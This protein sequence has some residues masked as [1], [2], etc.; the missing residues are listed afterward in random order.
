MAKIG[1]ICK[2]QSGGTPSKANQSFYGGQIPWITTVSLNGS[3]IDET[4][5]IEWIT[6][7]AIKNSAAK[8]VPENSILIGTRVGIGKTAINRVAMSTSQDVISLT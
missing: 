7:G 4:N 8:L 5:A 3:Y 6:E 2:F 1:D